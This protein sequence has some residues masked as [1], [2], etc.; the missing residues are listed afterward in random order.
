MIDYW[1]IQLQESERSLPMI[2][3]WSITIPELTGD[4]KRHAY[5]YVPND[6]KRNPDQR[7]PVLYMFDGHNVFFDKDAT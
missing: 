5:V 3:K 2:K 4:Q 7:Y 1:L 6:F